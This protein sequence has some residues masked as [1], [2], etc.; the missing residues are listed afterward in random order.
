MNIAHKNAFAERERALENE[1]FYRVDK[2]LLA[3]MREKLAGEEARNVLSA[4]S[5][6][7]DPLVIDEL[8]E[9]GVRPESLAAVNLIPLILVAWS[10]H[11]VPDVERR[12]VLDV[13]TGE[14]IAKQSPAYELLEHWLGVE[15]SPNLGQAWIHYISALA[16]TLTPGA[17]DA[18]KT[19]VMS[20][21]RVV[22]KS[23]HGILGFGH[24][25]AEELQTLQ[26][27]ENAFNSA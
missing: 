14:G 16:G 10:N 25:A 22:A 6:F 26:Q 21:A 13:A 9:L 2:Q 15:P 7:D 24:L 5:Q 8:F 23:A 27:L 20:R 17:L 4:M 12:T 18:L 1:F 19:D 3:D 11:N